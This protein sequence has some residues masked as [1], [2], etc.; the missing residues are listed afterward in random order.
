MMILTRRSILKYIE[1]LSNDLQQLGVSLRQIPLF[2][3]STVNYQNTGY[4][5]NITFKFACCSDTGG[6]LY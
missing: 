3:N 6:P 1:I 4:L 2:I 5:L